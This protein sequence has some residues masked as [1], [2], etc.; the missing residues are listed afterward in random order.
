MTDREIAERDHIA[1]I[2]TVAG[3]RAEIART[4]EVELPG[5]RGRPR[6]IYP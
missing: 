6:K 2:H 3:K 5:R 4:L 1:Q